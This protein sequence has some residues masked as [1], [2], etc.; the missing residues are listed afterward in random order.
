MTLA[1]IGLGVS[2]ARRFEDRRRAEDQALNAR[3][4]HAT[5]RLHP[6]GIERVARSRP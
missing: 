2:L 3:P 4:E 1:N 5:G 6:D